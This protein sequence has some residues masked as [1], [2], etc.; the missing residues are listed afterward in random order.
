MTSAEARSSAGSVLC[1]VARPF[2]CPGVDLQPQADSTQIAA[3]GLWHLW[4]PGNT[5]L[6]QLPGFPLLGQQ[7]EPVSASRS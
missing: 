3:V 1:S 5:L 6:W 2:S 7:R 4:T